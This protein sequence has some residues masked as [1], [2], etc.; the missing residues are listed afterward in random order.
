MHSNLNLVLIV[1]LIL[2][3]GTSCQ[4]ITQSNVEFTDL[5]RSDI[6]LCGPDASFAAFSYQLPGN[7]NIG[8]TNRESIHPRLLGAGLSKFP[9]VVANDNRTPAGK[10]VNGILELN[11]E[12]LW[13]DFRVETNDRPGLKV[14]AIAE[15]GK[16][17]S[18]PGPLIRVETGIQVRASIRNKSDS[19][20][21]IFGLQQRPANIRDSLVLKPGETSTLSFKA[22]EPGT[23]FYWIQP[24]FN[25]FEKVNEDEDEFVPEYD[26]LAGAFI[27]DPKGES[28]P[29]RIFVM[30]IF[31]TPIDTTL[32]PYGWL[33]ALTINGRS[34][35]FTELVKLDV[36]DTSRWR[37]INASK[38]NHPMHLHGFYYDVTS[39]GSMLNDNIYT[40]E[41]RRTV[42]TEFMQGE[43]TMSMEWV[44]SRSG[45]WL[46][47]CHLS[48]HV[49]PEIRLPGASQKDQGEHEIHMS[50]LVI[51]IEVK[52]GPSDL[53]A[54]G[55]PRSISLYANEYKHGATNSYK[56]T[57]SPNTENEKNPDVRIGPLIVLKQYQETFITVE[58]SMPFPTSIHWHGLEL[59]SWADGVPEWS[60]SDGL[61]S[62]TLNPGD[63]FTYKL[64][65]MRA[66]T[67]I[68]HSHLD[69]V[70]QL[71]KGLYGPMIVLGEN[72]IYDPKKDHC[73][74]FGWKSTD[75]KSKDDL[76]VNGVLEQPEKHA[77]VGEQ[78]RFRV[79]NISPAG[80]T[81]VRM[82]KG[83]T[84]IPLKFIAKDGA[85]LPAHQ[86]VF[87][88]ESQRFGVGET[89]DYIFSPTAL[90]TYTLLLIAFGNLR[91]EQKW[92]VAAK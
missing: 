36:G 70:H 89:G 29:D 45:K 53:I 64:S 81:S 49:A 37:I 23:Y 83:E 6:T 16:P 38:R 44:A 3:V 58:N 18:I 28:K 54:H 26:Q 2:E 60:S 32:H 25:S 79:M 21:T 47:H 80:R 5:I 69:D 48:F 56:F 8:K 88:N 35:P 77:K 4:Q 11:L 50:G 52:A 66:G 20:L 90:G 14:L 9:R 84:V 17:P 78:H 61:T 71:T 51:G 76:D 68:Y 74:I 85:D 46:F 92:I 59:D 19:T 22:G 30:N 34:W 63:K 86:Q 7:V 82:M 33:E 62:P 57:T 39:S 15:S 40:A 42:V 73:Y 41:N 65:L 67:F 75:P 24:F 72:E 43:T 87:V 55:N 31:S 27:I 1:S 13:S 91:W 10:M 12:V